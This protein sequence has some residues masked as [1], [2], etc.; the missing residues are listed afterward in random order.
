[1]TGIR[2]SGILTKMIEDDW[3][4]RDLFR[5]RVHLC[6]SVAILF[7]Q[8]EDLHATRRNELFVIRI[9]ADS[10]ILEFL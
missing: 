1:M 2:E 10:K 3:E 5:I 4:R 6:P 7:F 8:T 9:S